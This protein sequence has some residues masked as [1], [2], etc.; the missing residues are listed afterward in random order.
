MKQTIKKR[1]H[2]IDE[3]KLEAA[4]MAEKFK[5]TDERLGK[6]GKRRFNF[7]LGRHSYHWEHAQQACILSLA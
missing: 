2:N 4:V 6:G 1:L 7:M 3:N 5:E